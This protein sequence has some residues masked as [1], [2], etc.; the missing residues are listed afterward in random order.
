MTDTEKDTE[1]TVRCKNGHIFK[2][3]A[4]TTVSKC[5]LCGQLVAFKYNKSV[6]GKYY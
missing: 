1:K 2:I 3:P 5:P 4:T 6:G